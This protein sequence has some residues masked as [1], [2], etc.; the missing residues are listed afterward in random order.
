MKVRVKQT[1]KLFGWYGLKRRY[2]GDEFEIAGRHELGS[3]MELI[4]EEVMRVDE[5]V[6]QKRARR[7]KAQ[8]LADQANN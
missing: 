3:W 1:V 5:P 7:T 6:V 8:M 2:P 4:D